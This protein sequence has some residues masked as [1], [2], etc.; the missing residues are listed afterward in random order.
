MPVSQARPL[1]RG[2]GRYRSRDQTAAHAARHKG[3]QKQAGRG[4]EGTK[5]DDEEGQPPRTPGAVTVPLS[6]PLRN[7]V[8][9][10]REAGNVDHAAS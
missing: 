7:P 4:V 8:S 10:P 2:P 9:L 6:C 5:R 1:A 3:A